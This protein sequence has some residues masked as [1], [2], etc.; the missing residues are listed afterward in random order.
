MP[1]PVILLPYID[2]ECSSTSI[3]L[4]SYLFKAL[5][6]IDAMAGTIAPTS[7]GAVYLFRIGIS[8]VR[9]IHFQYSVR[10]LQLGF[11]NSPEN[12][13]YKLHSSQPLPVGIPVA[14]FSHL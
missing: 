11:P 6:V 13:P 12:P 8:T 7:T 4:I 1:P 3:A 14:S 2:A 5:T 9:T 10:H